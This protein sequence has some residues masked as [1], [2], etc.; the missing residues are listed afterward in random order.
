MEQIPNWE[1]NRFALVKKVP[2]HLLNPKVL[3]A[4]TS[5]RHVSL[6]W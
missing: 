1:A 5:A 4:F 3:T 6:S 2:R